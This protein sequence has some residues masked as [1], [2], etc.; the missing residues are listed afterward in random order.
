MSDLSR[1]KRRFLEIEDEKK[2]LHKMDEIMADQSR[3]KE[4]IHDYVTQI[5]L[6]K[7]DDSWVLVIVQFLDGSER[8]GTIKS[9]RYKKSELS[10][11]D[12]MTPTASLT[13]ETPASSPKLST[14]APSG[15]IPLSNSTGL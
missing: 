11:D 5:V 14:V 2:V 9:E 7:P 1:R 4:Y 12:T 6:F 15:S 3:V 10:N 8:W 13:T